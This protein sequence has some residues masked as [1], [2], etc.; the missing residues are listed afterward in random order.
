MTSEVLFETRGGVLIVTFN[1][2]EIGNAF[3]CYMAGLMEEKFKAAADNRGI[4]AI[5]LRGNGAHFMN[6]HDLSVYADNMKAAQDQILQKVQLFYAC[7]REMQV[8][9]KPIIAAV[10]GRVAGAGLCFMLACDLVI[11]AK[12][13]IFNADFTSHAMVPDG[14]VTFFLPRKVGATRA[15]EILTLNEDFSV[16]TADKWGLINKSVDADVLAAESLAWTDKIASGATRS[17]GATKRLIAKSFEQDINAQLSMEAAYWNTGCKTF[18]FA[19]A[20]KAHVAKRPEKFT[21]A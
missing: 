2:P 10:Q 21:G 5:L 7:I 9:E 12:S 1:R 18:D 8:M 11:A 4:R 6:G 3:T 17:F 16:E 19:E 13:T 15:M 14:G 20:M